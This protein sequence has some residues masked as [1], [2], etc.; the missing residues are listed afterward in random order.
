MKKAVSVAIAVL[1][2]AVLLGGGWFAYERYQL[3][4]LQ[5][6]EFEEISKPRGM[7]G[8]WNQS[9]R[10]LT[11]KITLENGEIRWAPLPAGGGNFASYSAGSLVIQRTF[12]D[13]PV[14]SM[15]IVLG[16]GGHAHFD[17]YE[18]RFELR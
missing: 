3:L 7:L 12:N 16:D 8:F 11:V 13:E 18:D 2:L 10:H 1:A 17:V 15:N 9:D 5:K 6:K 14:V 4:K